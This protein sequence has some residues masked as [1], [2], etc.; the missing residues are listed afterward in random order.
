MR[1]F[2]ALLVVVVVSTTQVACKK[3]EGEAKAPPADAKHADAASGSEQATL[4]PSESEQAA[5]D[6]LPG[7]A[8]QL[9]MMDRAI[10]CYPGGAPEGLE[11]KIIHNSAGEID[12]VKL[13]PAADEATTAC[14]LAKVKTVTPK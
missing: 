4:E 12:S 3:G 9:A 7:E 11:V 1:D 14:V 2:L 13:T 8:E 10:E 6:R 5:L